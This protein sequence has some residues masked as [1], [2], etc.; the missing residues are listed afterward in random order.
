M[1]Q[2]TLFSF[3]VPENPDALRNPRHSAWRR[4]SLVTLDRDWR[5]R[6]FLKEQ[7]LHW[8]NLTQ[9]ASLWNSD[10][11][12]LLVE[13]WFESL[14][15]DGDAIELILRPENCEDYFHW[16]VGPPDRC[17]DCHV[18][19]PR[20]DLD[21]QWS[22]DSDLTVSIGQEERI[23]R[24]FL[25]LPFRPILRASQCSG[26]PEVGDVWGIN[27]AR[28]VGSE[29]TREVAIW[30]PPYTAQPDFHQTACLGNLMFLET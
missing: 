4:D 27:L 11:L 20:V 3:F 2:N 28:I 8:K 22:S 13:C 18:M 10:T 7:G 23:W 15:R 29:N 16:E 19:E 14:D 17:L 12:F 26:N 1:P 30:R 21:Y 9:V 5:G 6:S 24:A 25:A